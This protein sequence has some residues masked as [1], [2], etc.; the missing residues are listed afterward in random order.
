MKLAMIVLVLGG[1][2]SAELLPPVRYVKAGPASTR[3][4][5]RIVAVPATCGTFELQA[6]KSFEAGEM[7]MVPKTCGPEAVSGADQIVRLD[8]AFRG[9]VVIDSENV[10]AVTAKVVEKRTSEQTVASTQAMTSQHGSD[11]TEIEREGAR[12]E[13]APPLEQAAILAELR[14]DAVLSTRIW[15]GASL[16]MSGRR[17]VIAQ[18]QLLATLDRTLVWSRRCEMEVAGI[19]GTESVSIERATRCAMETK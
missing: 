12:F 11:A 1:C 7:A 8:L 16:G 3:P 15:I 5:S 14:A 2:S 13:D 4:I 19:F 18:V 10:N 17:V 9:F 6:A